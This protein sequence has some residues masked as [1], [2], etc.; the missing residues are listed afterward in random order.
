MVTIPFDNDVL[1]TTLVVGQ[2][3]RSIILES[4]AASNKVK[5]EIAV[6]VVVSEKII[7]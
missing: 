1:P 5:K 4:I 3:L 6:K 2:D 7:E